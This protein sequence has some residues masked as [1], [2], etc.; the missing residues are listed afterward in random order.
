MSVAQT[1]AIHAA[2]TETLEGVLAAGQFRT[3]ALADARGLMWAVAGTLPAPDRLAAMPSLIARAFTDRQPLLRFF[4]GKGMRFEYRSDTAAY[5]KEGVEGEPS[6]AEFLLDVPAKASGKGARS[7]IGNRSDADPAASGEFMV[8][9]GGEHL[10]MRRVALEDADWCVMGLTADPD[11]AR[12]ALRKAAPALADVLGGQANTRS[13]EMPFDETAAAL[14]ARMGLVLESFREAAPEIHMAAVTSK[15]GF[16]VAALADTVEADTVAPL[17][18]HS[19]LAIQESTQRLCGET[20][21]VM[22][23]MAD[24]ILLA[25]ELTDDLLFA[26][27]LAPTACTGLILTA[28]ET[29]ANGLCRAL[30]GVAS[31]A[32]AAVGMEAV[33]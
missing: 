13:R 18:G 16:V 25:R 5:I 22:L 15:D 29:A 28:F 30:H 11:A 7:L 17:I 1:T 8:H 20:E 3:V 9:W 26:A 19:F 33:A 12:E 4:S 32:S 24:G 23:R 6:A 21:C 2:L 14:H 10:V 31:T 27:L